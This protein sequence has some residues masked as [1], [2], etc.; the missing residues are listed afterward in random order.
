MEDKDGPALAFPDLEEE[1]VIIGHSENDFF[2]ANI[3]PQEIASLA[4]FFLS[5]NMTKV[6]EASCW[7]EDKSHQLLYLSW[8]VLGCDFEEQ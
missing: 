6:V 5:Q 4:A 8:R 7:I 2:L 1:L 3:D